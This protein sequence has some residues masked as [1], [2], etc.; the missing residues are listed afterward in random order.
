MSNL[1]E[2]LGPYACQASKTLGRLHVEK[3]NK[4]RSDFQR[5]R[6][7][8]IHSAAFRKLM[9]KTQVFIGHEGDLFRTRL[10]HSIE[11]S[12]VARA[13]SRRLKLN[14]DL[15]EALC[16]AHDLGHTPF[17]HT[18]QTSLNRCLKKFHSESNGF[19]HNIQSLRVVDKL[20]NKYLEFDGLNLCFETRE[21]ILKHCSKRIA[22]RLGKIAE[23]FVRGRLP[24]LE[25][26]LVNVADEIA[27]NHHD[28]DDGLRSGLLLFDEI[29]GLGAAKKAVSEVVSI[30]RSLDDYRK[31]SEVIRRMI[32]S[33]IEDLVRQT[34]RNIKM[35]GV[36]SVDEVRSFGKVLVSFSPET[37]SK[38]TELKSFLMRRLYKNP[39]VKQLTDI[40]EVVVSDLFSVF[41]ADLRV[42]NL[43]LKSLRAVADKIAG[44]T[45]SSA[46]RMHNKFF[47]E[48]GKLHHFSQKGH[49][50]AEI[51]MDD[52][53]RIAYLDSIFSAAEKNKLIIH[54]YQLLNHEAH[55][56]VTPK[57]GDSLR[58][59]VQSV[60]REYVRAFNQRWGRTGTLWDGRYRSYVID[61][62]PTVE[63]NIQKYLDKLPKDN[64]LIR[65]EV[66]WKWSSC[67]YYCGTLS[68]VQK[69]ITK[70]N[71]WSFLFPI[72]AYWD[73]G[74]TPFERQFKYR[75]FLKRSLSDEET[76]QIR[77]S[78]S[79]GVPKLK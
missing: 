53:D 47:P 18:G 29:I 11:V 73:L 35:S 50:N 36:N 9:H 57:L 1:E 79:R 56:M 62:K 75:E 45:D 20:E 5:D 19:E 72:S 58:L 66:Q 67:A 21:G 37:Q 28:L 65:D 68:Q 39:Q 30:G 31:N 6:D 41:V 54:A 76:E 16:L 63:L 4:G 40:A 32:N 69:L 14:E 13:I 34:Q 60:G 70:K 51:F 49:N 44:M 38:V 46:V 48:K 43:D 12:Q 24:S 64:G 15:T 17:G 74:N 59:T 10:T 8:V 2:S 7:R 61:G 71:Y 77:K 52:K 42:S 23:R 33:Q 25:A 22:P 26:Q 78:L 27:Y 55:W 3:G